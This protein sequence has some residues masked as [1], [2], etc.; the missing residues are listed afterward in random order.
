MVTIQGTERIKGVLDLGSIHQQLVKGQVLHLKD[1]D[2]WQTDVQTALKMGWVVSKGTP[3]PANISPYTGNRMIKCVNTHHRSISM[4]QNEREIRPGQ[5]F[6]LPEQDMDT[7]AV[8]AAVARGMIKPLGV[9]AAEGT[10]SEGK[11]YVK[12]R[13]EGVSLTPEHQSSPTEI[14]ISD[15]MVASE[16]VVKVELDTNEE[17]ATPAIIKDKKG[18][19][20]NKSEDITGP[21]MVITDEHPAAVDP[22]INDPKRT[23]IVVDPNKT[24]LNAYIASKEQNITFVDRAQ[25]REKIASHPKLR[26]QPPPQ[27]EGTVIIEDINN[28]EA[29]IAS[30]PVLSK[31]V[32]DADAGVDFIDDLDIME[33]IEK[34]PV[35]GQNSEE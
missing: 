29:R 12:K 16:G 31:Q 27:D 19:T 34:H 10:E 23:S 17:L 21:S 8:R 26:N 1:D 13:L 3:S 6:V 15:D 24:R 28:D 2:F 5:T 30:H 7:P 18:V 4:R 9:A 33:R 20:W 32:K 25:E 22:N 35:L 14:E 11:V